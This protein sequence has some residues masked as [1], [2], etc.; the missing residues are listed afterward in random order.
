MQ[1]LH[2]VN[3]YCGILHGSA[4]PYCDTLSLYV[5]HFTDWEHYNQLLFSYYCSK[6]LFFF[7]FAIYD[8]KCLLKASVV[9]VLNQV[10]E[11]MSS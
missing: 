5:V 9:A 11:A 1:Q 4:S 6:M 8:N 10:S 7:A 3:I 2:L